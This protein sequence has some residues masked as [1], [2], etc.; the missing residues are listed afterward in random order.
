MSKILLVEDE[1]FM[2]D[3]SDQCAIIGPRVGPRVIV[4]GGLLQIPSQGA[5]RGVLAD[6]Q[7]R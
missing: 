2:V 4:T 6:A 3:G 5:T 1:A 7:R